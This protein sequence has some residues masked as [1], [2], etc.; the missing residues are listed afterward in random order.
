MGNNEMKTKD[1]KEREIS[2]QGEAIK[3]HI[4][5]GIEKKERKKKISRATE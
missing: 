2:D 1:E 4:I 3:E 5:E